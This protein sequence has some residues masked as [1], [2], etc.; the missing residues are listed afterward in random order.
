[1]T[2]RQNKIEAEFRRDGTFVE[3]AQEEEFRAHI[4][5]RECKKLSAIAIP[6]ALAVAAPLPLDGLAL[7]WGN[8]LFY[9]DAAIR[10]TS[11][12]LCAVVFLVFRH[13]PKNR[14]TLAIP[15]ATTL[16]V[17]VVIIF[18][19]ISGANSIEIA[20]SAAIM[21]ILCNW[22]FVPLKVRDLLI[23]CLS[24]WLGYTIISLALSPD[25]LQS[26]ILASILLFMA[27]LIGLFYVRNRNI[28]E[29]REM[30][31]AQELLAT[32]E[33]LR[34]EIATRLAAEKHAG[35]NEEIFRGVFTSCPVP[36]CMIDPATGK[37]TRA[38]KRMTAFLG[39]TEEEWLNQ[40]VRSLFVDEDAFDEAVEILQRDRSVLY[41]EIRMRTKEGEIRWALLSARRFSMPEG[42]T[43]LAS[44]V[45][46]TDQKQKELDL[47]IATEE[48][49]KANVS[50]SQFLAN[51]SHELRTP[52]NAIIGFS[53]I[54]ESEVFGKID[55][56]R[57]LGYMSDIKSSGIHLLSII[58]E[59]LD[60]SKIEANAK[61]LHQEE[62]DLNEVVDIASR[63]IRHHAQEK[64][65]QLHVNLSGDDPVLMGDERAIKQIILNLLSN[66]VKFTPDEGSIIIRTLQIGSRVVV[67]ISDTGVGI[68]EDQ[69]DT[70]AEP[71][72][73]LESTLSSTK[74]GTGLGLSIATRLAELHGGRIDFES[75]VCEGTTARLTL[76]HI[77][78]DKLAL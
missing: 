16:S 39:Y 72:V 1:M 46:I 3:Q 62:V 21:V 13:P 69:L 18:S 42:E 70:I 20:A 48:A 77:R 47:A 34:Q 67:E 52:L 45:D 57:Y 64:S 2:L 56:E 49:E 15:F 38:N 55:N 44:F 76:P 40:P 36:L 37:F 59:I 61:E 33:S 41:D 73:Q 29:R 65:I 32:T 51:M 22:A 54:M 75:I 25:N 27:N 9:A 17:N 58:N 10:T 8:P 63:L 14:H 78:N 7:G 28:S 71:F 43:A 6:V 26:V 68:P 30:L 24:V 23:S 31:V 66:A 60:L 53:D 50:K 5:Q 4:W 12:F 74:T 35:A 19:I 11:V